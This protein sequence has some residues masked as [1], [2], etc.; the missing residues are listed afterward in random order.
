MCTLCQTVNRTNTFYN[1][2]REIHTIVLS[3]ER[4]DSLRATDPERETDSEMF[5]TQLTMWRQ[6]MKLNCK[7]WVFNVHYEWKMF[8]H[9]VSYRFEDILKRLLL[10]TQ[11]LMW[12]FFSFLFFSQKHY[13]TLKDIQVWYPLLT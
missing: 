9:T 4:A 10:T 1:I 2:F 5:M 7:R 3:F 13:Y 6:S 8:T 11:V 12:R